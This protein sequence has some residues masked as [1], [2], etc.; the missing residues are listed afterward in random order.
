MELVVLARTAPSVEHR[1]QHGR[2]IAEPDESWILDRADDVDA[3]GLQDLPN[4]GPEPGL[5]A[6]VLFP[7]NEGCFVGCDVQP[8]DSAGLRVQERTPSS[9]AT[10]SSSDTDG[11]VVEPALL[12]RSRF[13]LFPSAN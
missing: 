12:G 10:D 8:Y 7:P 4:P 6:H 2:G 13:G 9:E 11:K 3:H 1:D 5:L